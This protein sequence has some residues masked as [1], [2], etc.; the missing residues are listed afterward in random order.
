M[1]NRKSILV[2]VGTTG[3]DELIREICSEAFVSLLKPN[4]FDSII[5][6]FGS[7]KKE[8]SSS[9]FNKYNVLFE[10]CLY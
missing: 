3:F 5:I 9:N 1:I 4:G 7:S 10:F 8:Y 2:T 6:Q